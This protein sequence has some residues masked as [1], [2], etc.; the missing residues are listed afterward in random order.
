MNSILSSREKRVELIKSLICKYNIVT[1][2]VNMFGSIKNNNLSKTILGYFINVINNNDLFKKAESLY[3]KSDDGDYIIYKFPKSIINLKEETIKIEESFFGR[4]IDL[5]V[6]IDKPNSIYREV[7]R[8]CIICNNPAF[9]CIREKKHSYNELVLKYKE[10]TYPYIEKIISSA[11]YESMIQELNLSPKFGSVCYDSNGS[12]KDLNYS[13]MK[14]CAKTI[15]QGFLDMFKVGYF[16]NDVKEL[17]PLI[18]K[19][20]IKQEEL[21]MNTYQ[22]NCYK[23]LIFCLG[24]LI[25]SLGRYLTSMEIISFDDAITDTL[26]SYK[27]K[28]INTFGYKKYQEGF[29]GIRGEV[30]KHYPT[31]KKISKSIDIDNYEPVF[32]SFLDIV[33]YSD[34]T[35]LLKRAKDYNKYLEY[36]NKIS[37]AYKLASEDLTKLNNDCIN[38]NISLGGS[39]D[40]LVCALTIKRIEKSLNIKELF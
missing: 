38:N 21:M 24:I 1:L 10:L 33:R 32:K 2:K 37:N 12:H 9:V 14:N 31:L 25:C 34:D 17:F 23:G 28:E 11:I 8:K 5:D 26:V 4:L 35:V 6:Y 29:L 27:I 19:I 15:N 39:C 40:L 3:I 30:T 20:G 36:K 16:N 18:N 13:I 7:L 22:T